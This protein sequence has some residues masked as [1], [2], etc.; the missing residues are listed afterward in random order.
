MTELERL[1]GVGVLLALFIR[2]T[3]VANDGLVDKLRGISS[4]ENQSVEIFCFLFFGFLIDFL[5]YQS[6]HLFLGSKYS[7]L[8]YLMAV[9]INEPLFELEVVVTKNEA[10]KKHSSKIMDYKLMAN[11]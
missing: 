5:T 2:D 4:S 6:V 8:S 1:V 11:L 3:D 9:V 10:I 7:L